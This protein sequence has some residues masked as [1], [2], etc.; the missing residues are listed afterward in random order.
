MQ[1]ELLQEKNLTAISGNE[2]KTIDI[3]LS[4]KSRLLPYSSTADMF[5]LN[6]LYI[7]ERDECNKYRMIFTVNPICT[8]VLYNSVTEPVFKE[9]SVSATSL[10]QT[11]VESGDTNYFPEGTIN[12]TSPIDQKQ[13]VKDTEYSHE[14]IG[15]FEYHC[16]Y[17][18]FNNHLLRTMDFEHVGKSPD[19]DKIFNTI[20]DY[21]VNYDGKTVLSIEAGKHGEAYGPYTS[22]TITD[23]DKEKVRMYQLDN[24]KTM[25]VAF[26]DGLRVVDGWYGFYNSGYINLPNTKLGSNK[27]DIY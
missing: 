12:K 17:D 23:S 7:K 14:R 20:E 27:E 8:N 9:G 13:A 10:V 19:N 22:T 3:D 15:N 26:Y 5:S 21:V 6:D 18:I 4:S 2:E 24:I 11:S 25:D 16:G 1:R